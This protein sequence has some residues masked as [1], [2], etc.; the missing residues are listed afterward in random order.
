MG[1]RKI[2]ALQHVVPEGLWA[3]ADALAARNVEVELI[4]VHRGQAIPKTLDVDG[5]I[6]MGGPMGVYDP[7]PYLADERRLIESALQ[8]NKPVLGICLGSQLL[9]SVLG[10]TVKPSGRQEIGWHKV[11]TRPDP[12]WDGIPSSFTALHWHG[13]IFD[14]PPGAKLLA[15]SEMT[16]H[17]AFRVGNAWGLLFHLEQTRASLAGMANAFPEDLAKVGL[18]GERLLEQATDYLPTLSDIG[19]KVFG[20]WIDRLD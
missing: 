14:L 6:V 19:V 18:T 3:I 4:E 1:N 13:D 5:L 20:R 17:Q 11:N 10:A 7:L 2:L 12:I 15:S 16:A 9:A 8:K